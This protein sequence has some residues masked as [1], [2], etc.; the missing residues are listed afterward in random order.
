MTEK[1]GVTNVTMPMAMIKRL[2]Y[3]L[4]SEKAEE[5]GLSSRRQVIIM[6]LRN[7]LDEIEQEAAVHNVD[8]PNLKYVDC[9]NGSV[10]I[11]DKKL[12]KEVQ[13]RKNSSGLLTCQECKK[14]CIHFDYYFQTTTWIQ[15]LKGT[16]EDVFSEKL[17]KLLDFFPKE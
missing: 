14:G 5:L 12:N 9:R 16:E 4:E 7:F 15:H 2:D 17:L 1:S 11:Y 6:L 8:F 13:L 3:Y 10:I